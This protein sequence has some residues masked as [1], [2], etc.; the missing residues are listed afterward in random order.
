MGS[1]EQFQSRK[2]DAVRRTSH[3][4]EIVAK[5]ESKKK[6]AVVR[7]TKLAHWHGIVRTV[8]TIPKQEERQLQLV[9]KSLAEL[10]SSYLWS[11][12]ANMTS[13]RKTPCAPHRI[14]A[15]SLLNLKARRKTPWCAELNWHTGMG[16]LEQF[17]SRKKD[18]V[19]RTSHW[20]PIVVKDDHLVNDKFTNTLTMTLTMT[21]PANYGY[22]HQ[23]L[24]FF[25]RLS[26]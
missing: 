15:G 13:R 2:K 21:I 7:R 17:P 8:R 25:V 9:Q 20:H 6:Y 3:W 23:G 11:S 1:L 5:F 22:P 4:R 24:R 12:G 10:Q 26:V 19:R 14:G 16:S 18:A